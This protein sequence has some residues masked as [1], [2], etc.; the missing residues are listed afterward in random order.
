MRV[1]VLHNIHRDAS[2]GLNQ[3]F[4]RDGKH[5]E[6]AS[7][8]LVKVFEFDTTGLPDPGEN[9]PTVIADAIF[10]A[11]NVGHEPGYATSSQEYDLAMAYR[12]RNLRSL[13]VGDVL[14][15]EGGHILVCER[16]GWFAVDESDLWVID[17]PAAERMIRV[18]YGFRPGEPLSVT[19]PLEG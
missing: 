15:F 18:R 3:I 17:A 2:F 13:S 7:H 9:R 14:V 4:D 19:V 5:H 11:F 1:T 6:A 12:A 10:R 8:E 16:I